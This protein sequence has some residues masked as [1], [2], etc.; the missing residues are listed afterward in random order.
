VNVVQAITLVKRDLGAVSKDKRM[1]SGP[2]RYSYRS[3]DDVLNKLHAPL[4]EHGLVIAPKVA[5]VLQEATGVT[6]KSG[7]SITHTM[8]DVLYLVYG[9]E[10]DTIEVRTFGEALDSGDKGYNKAFT[11]AFK[12]CLTQVLAIPFATDDMDDYDTSDGGVTAYQSQSKSLSAPLK[13]AESAPATGTRPSASRPSESEIEPSR[14]TWAPS[15]GGTVPRKYLGRQVGSLSESDR[16][17]LAT[18]GD[19]L[20]LPAWDDDAI[21]AEG[22]N[23]YLALL[24]GLSHAERAHE[25]S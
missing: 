16:A 21:T 15:S 18:M 6:T 11:A 20:G 9:P 1:E 3:I 2:A 4:V 12:G 19:K 13:P 25:G 24:K 10:G 17:R 7:A 8:V 23:K 5:Q 22:V 14:E